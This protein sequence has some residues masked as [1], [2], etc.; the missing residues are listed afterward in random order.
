M[1]YKL[2]SNK[3]NYRYVDILFHYYRKN[4]G[5]GRFHSSKFALSPNCECDAAEQTADH[6]LTACSI[7]RAPH[8]TRGPT[9]L[10]DETRCWLNNITSSI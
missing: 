6:I 1:F 2:C 7:H 10:D 4:N 8:E 3:F 9:V 5:V